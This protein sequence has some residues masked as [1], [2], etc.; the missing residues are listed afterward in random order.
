MVFHNGAKPWCC[1]FMYYNVVTKRMDL[2]VKEMGS[3]E[4]SL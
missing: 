2:R 1:T 4:L 3:A